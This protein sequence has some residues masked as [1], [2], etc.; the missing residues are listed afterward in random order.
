[1]DTVW[2]VAGFA[3]FPFI[4]ALVSASTDTIGRRKIFWAYDVLALIIAAV[5]FMLVRDTLASTVLSGHGAV[6]VL[7]STMLALG[8][9]WVLYPLT[10]RVIYG[11]VKA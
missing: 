6:T 5:S 11:L 1:M 8:S 4:V 3:L 10:Y 9:L 2:T 7:A